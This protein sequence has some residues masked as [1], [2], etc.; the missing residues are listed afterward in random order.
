MG[1]WARGEGHVQEGCRWAGEP[2]HGNQPRRGGCLRRHVC[3]WPI[4]PLT[5][6]IHEAQSWNGQRAQINP[7]G[8]K[9]GFGAGLTLD[10]YKAQAHFQG[11]PAGTCPSVQ[12]HP[13]ARGQGQGVGVPVVHGAPAV[14]DGAGV[15]RGGAIISGSFRKHDSES[16][17]SLPGSQKAALLSKALGD[18]CTF[19]AHSVA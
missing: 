10:P 3:P 5:S 16:E 9:T 19:N 1:L 2:R 12:P 11:L 15:R 7:K 17:A 4:P 18:C 6:Q 14:C 8:R 13:A